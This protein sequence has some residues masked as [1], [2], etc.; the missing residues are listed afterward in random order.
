MKD[1]DAV[2]TKG[3]GARNVRQLC[4]I[5]YNVRGGVEIVQGLLDNIMLALKIPYSEEGSQEGYYLVGT[6]CKCHIVLQKFGYK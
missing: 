1:S 5:N 3:V 6:D 2:A 4:A